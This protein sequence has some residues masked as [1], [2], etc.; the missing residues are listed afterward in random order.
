[1]LRGLQVDAARMRRNLDL[2]GGLIVAE[3]VMMGLAPAIGRQ[4]A[5]DVVYDACRIAIE[6]NRTLYEV[7]AAD[8]KIAGRFSDTQLRALTDPA[9]YL[10]A[11]AEMARNVARATSVKAQ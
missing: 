10:G 11:A 6:Q 3:A 4:H 2:T 8:A 1:M 7:L 5:H 9:N